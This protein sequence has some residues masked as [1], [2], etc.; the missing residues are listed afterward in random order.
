MDSTLAETFKALG[1]PAIMV[2]PEVSRAMLARAQTKALTELVTRLINDTEP[3][4]RAE[5]QKD[6][7]S[8]VVRERGG[9]GVFRIT[10]D[11]DTSG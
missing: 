4:L 6:G 3:M 1:L 7:K 5:S 2:E 8:I 10:V 11:A 9:T